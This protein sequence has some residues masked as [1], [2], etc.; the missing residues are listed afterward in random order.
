MSCFGLA[1]ELTSSAN[2]PK[3]SPSFSIATSVKVLLPGALLTATAAC[4]ALTAAQLSQQLGCLCSS[5]VAGHE[6]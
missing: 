1:A 3:V 5:S 4:N 6:I 2:S